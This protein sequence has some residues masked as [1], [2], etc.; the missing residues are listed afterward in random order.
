MIMLNIK[1]IHKVKTNKTNRI[2]QNPY[3]LDEPTQIC[4]AQNLWIIYRARPRVET[5]LIFK[6]RKRLVQSTSLEKFVQTKNPSK[7]V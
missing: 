3:T 2:T 4:F 7:V 6:Q 1:K 5:N